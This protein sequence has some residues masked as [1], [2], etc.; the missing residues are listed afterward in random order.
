MDNDGAS[1]ENICIFKDTVHFCKSYN[2][3]TLKSITD[4]TLHKIKT[5]SRYREDSFYETIKENVEGRFYHSGCYANY[6]SKD[7]I[8]RN[9]KKSGKRALTGDTNPN[10]KRTR[11]SLPSFDFKLHCLF[12]GEFCQILLGPKNPSPSRW[13]KAFFYVELLIGVVERS[14]LKK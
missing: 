4:I 5:C 2:K 12:C 9:L 6:T 10:R 3:D 8:N 11:P 1:T 14:R 13:K 7:H